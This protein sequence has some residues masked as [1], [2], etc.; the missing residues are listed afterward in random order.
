[1]QIYKEIINEDNDKTTL[2]NNV[3]IDSMIKS[4]IEIDKII[5]EKFIYG[6]NG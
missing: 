3:D 6:Y 2:K 1:M 5:T 4:L